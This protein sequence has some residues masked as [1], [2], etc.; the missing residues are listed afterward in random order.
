MLQFQETSVI[1]KETEKIIKYKDL[2]LEE[3]VECKK[4]SDSNNRSISKSLK[5]PEQHI[6]KARNQVTTENSHIGH[7]TR[8]LESTNVKVQKI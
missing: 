7:S 4:C 2:T 1:K 5:V 6:G 8:T 3:H